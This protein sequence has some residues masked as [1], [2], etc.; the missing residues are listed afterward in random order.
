METI[1]LYDMRHNV[2]DL[3]D[4]IEDNI[5][6]IR[7]YEIEHGEDIILGSPKLFEEY[8]KLCNKLEENTYK[9][10]KMMKTVRSFRPLE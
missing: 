4:D 8:S 10:D 3:A 6:M 1:E 5:E 2:T 9:M 7:A